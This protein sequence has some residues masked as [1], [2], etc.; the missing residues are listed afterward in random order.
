MFWINFF[1]STKVSL[2]ER[3]RWFLLCSSMSYWWSPERSGSLAAMSESLASVI[4][5]LRT[6]S[7][8]CFKMIK[9]DFLIK[10]RL[11]ELIM[12]PSWFNS[13]LS[14]YSPCSLMLLSSL[15]LITISSIGFFKS[16]VIYSS[17]WKSLR[18]WTVRFLSWFM[19]FVKCLIRT[20]LGI[21]CLNLIRS[22]SVNLRNFAYS[23][24]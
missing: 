2:F 3:R 13:F 12:R 18:S 8:T 20:S 10:S 1:R 23:S 14:F 21:S 4:E 16:F 5:S 24:K 17:F 9:E 22:I 7:E 15:T 11:L 6:S 19:S